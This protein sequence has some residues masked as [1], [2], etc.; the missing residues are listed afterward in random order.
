MNEETPP[1]LFTGIS[2][3][4]AAAPKFISPFNLISWSTVKR[5]RAEGLGR[6]IKERQADILPS[7]TGM[8]LITEGWDK[9]LP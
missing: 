3:P 4:L 7:N 1:P 5:G 9:W 6:G 8:L 2:Q